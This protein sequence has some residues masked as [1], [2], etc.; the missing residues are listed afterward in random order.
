MTNSLVHLAATARH[1][2]TTERHSHHEAEVRSMQRG[3]RRLAAR[4][5]NGRPT[6]FRPKPRLDSV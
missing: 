4:G 6:R 2:P 3:L 5:I 1:L